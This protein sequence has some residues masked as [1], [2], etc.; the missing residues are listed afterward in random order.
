MIDFVG[1]FPSLRKAS[2]V[3][4]ATM[5]FLI[6]QMVLFMG[7]WFFFFFCIQGSQETIWHISNA[8]KVCQI[9]SWSNWF[10][11]EVSLFMMFVYVFTLFI[12][13]LLWIMVICVIRVLCFSSFRARPL[14]PC[15]HL[16]GKD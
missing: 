10:E 9:R 4:M 11:A 14:L 5:H 6:V 15:G 1:T 7:N 2:C 13:S 3:T 8:C 12:R 16:L